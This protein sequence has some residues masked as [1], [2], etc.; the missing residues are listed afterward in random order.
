MK[1]QRFQVG[2]WVIYTMD[3]AKYGPADYRDMGIDPD[4]PYEI[5][6][7][8]R[9]GGAWHY[10]LNKDNRSYE[11]WEL[12]KFDLHPPPAPPNFGYDKPEDNAIAANFIYGR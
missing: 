4:R 7:V 1:E 12:F 8:K 10:K 6:E 11:W 9:V 2:D 5:I 3:H